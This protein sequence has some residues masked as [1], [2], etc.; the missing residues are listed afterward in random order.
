MSA[1]LP[2]EDHNGPV[3]DVPYENSLILPIAATFER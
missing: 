1:A 3:H 2:Q